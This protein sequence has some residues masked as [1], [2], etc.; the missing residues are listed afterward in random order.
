M[1][2]FEWGTE[3]ID[4]QAQLLSEFML[5]YVMLFFIICYIILQILE[6][7]EGRERDLPRNKLMLDCPGCNYSN[8]FLPV[9]VYTNLYG[10]IN[11]HL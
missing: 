4:P 6:V 1:L 2:K 9:L 10:F 3:N 11:C 5:Y 7:G 8:A